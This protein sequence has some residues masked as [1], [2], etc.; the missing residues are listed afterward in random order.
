MINRREFLSLSALAMPAL[1]PAQSAPAP[2][3]GLMYLGAFPRRIFVIEEATGNVAG[4]IAMQ[5]GTPRGTFLSQDKKRFYVMADNM[6]DC[7]VVDIAGRRVTDTFRLSESATKKVRLRGMAVDP[8]E[9]YA[10]ILTRPYTKHIDRWEIGANSILQYDLKAKKVMR[11][12]P[13]PGGQEREGAFFKFSPDGKNLFLFGDDIVVLNTSD[14]KEADKWELSRPIEDGFGRINFNQMDDTYEEPG[15]MT[16]I[17]QVQ[18]AVQNRSIMGIARVNLQKK[19]V[20]FYA[21]G[22]SE[23]VSFTMAPD[24]K[25]GYGLKQQVGRYE[26]WKFDL[27]NKRLHERKEFAGRPRMNVKVSSNGKVLYIYVAGATIDLHDATDYRRLRTITL[28]GDMTSDLFL[29]PKA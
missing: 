2:G 17:F 24:R 10:V 29:L 18:D 16:G 4:E 1:A 7:E 8:Q 25:W 14:W 11:T 26:F 3:D 22:P 13:W 27:V 5:K 20:D 15:F 19:S 6:E 28:D 12:I 23:F 9:N 21:L